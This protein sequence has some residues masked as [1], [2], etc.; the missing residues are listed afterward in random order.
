MPL[1][2]RIVAIARVPNN[3]TTVVVLRVGLAQ[4]NVLHHGNKAQRNE[5]QDQCN[6]KLDTHDIIVRLVDSVP[7]GGI[8]CEHGRCDEAVFDR[9]DVCVCRDGQ[10]LFQPTGE[11]V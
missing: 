11:K 10:M 7:F 1:V 2:V 5:Q 4:I 3:N 8:P 6:Q 9:G